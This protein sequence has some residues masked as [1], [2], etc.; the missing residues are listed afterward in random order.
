MNVESGNLTENDGVDGEVRVATSPLSPSNKTGEPANVNPGGIVRTSVSMVFPLLPLT[1]NAAESA[2]TN[3]ETTGTLAHIPRLRRDP[4]GQVATS[5]R[6]EVRILTLTGCA[7]ERG[8]AIYH[9]KLGRRVDFYVAESTLNAH[10]LSGAS[11]CKS[12]LNLEGGRGANSKFAD[13]DRVR[14]RRVAS[15][16]KCG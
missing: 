2:Q 5:Q 13:D 3:G 15:P 12:L 9:P 8:R 11:G 14:I 4:R 10:P 16:G 6:I 7:E 1:V